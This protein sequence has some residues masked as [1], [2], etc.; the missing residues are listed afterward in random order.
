MVQTH[1]DNLVQT[2]DRARRHAHRSTTEP[3]WAYP[4]P[5][6][7]WSER[8]FQAELDLANELLSDIDKAAAELGQVRE[9]NDWGLPVPNNPGS[10][11]D[12]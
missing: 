8:Y 11:R 10:W 12:E 3:A 6:L 4:T 1:I 5:S 7:R 9:Y 2:R